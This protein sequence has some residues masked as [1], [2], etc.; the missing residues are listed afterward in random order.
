M[1]VELDPK[2]EHV[3]TVIREIFDTFRKEKKDDDTKFLTEFAKLTERINFMEKN[4][5]RF[6]ADQREQ[7]KL[8][9]NNNKT[10][11]RQ[12]IGLYAFI[13]TAILA[14]FTKFKH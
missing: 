5:E 6:E 11:N 8:I 10:A 3:V 2:E 4:D 14:L 13:G 1:R 7:D 12:T 9:I